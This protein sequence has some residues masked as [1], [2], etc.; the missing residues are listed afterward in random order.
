MEARH[1]SRIARS[2]LRQK[3]QRDGLLQ[4]QIGSAIYLAHATAPDQ[5]DNE[6]TL[7]KHRPGR[8]AAVGK[9]ADSGLE[10]GPGLVV[11]AGHGA[12]ERG[13]RRVGYAAVDR[14]DGV[15]IVPQQRLDLRSYLV[16]NPLLD[17][18]GLALRRGSICQLAKDRDRIGVHE[19][20]VRTGAA[21]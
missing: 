10:I 5:I 3:L 12:G 21:S 6:V 9:L 17:V 11:A 2:G 20:N 4:L 1:Q 13:P 15:A 14:A 16:G 8:K 19:A 18:V 7:G